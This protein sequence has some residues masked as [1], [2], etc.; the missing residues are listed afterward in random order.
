M[1]ST[2]VVKNVTDASHYYAA[3]DNYY[4]IEEGILKS[5]W[6]GRGSF[7][8]N[9][10]GAID[11][12]QFT[13]LLKGIMPN[14]EI[15]GK[16]VDDKIIHRAGWDLTFSA[17]KSVSLMALIAGDKRLVEAHRKAVHIALSE[18]ERGCSEARIKSPG[19]DVSYN[20]TR[21]MIAALFHHDLSRAEDPQLHTHS[22]VMN[23]TERTDGKWRS[24]ASKIGRY[25][26]DTQGEIHGFFERARHHK[27]Y[28]G[29]LYETE[30]AFQVQQLGYEIVIDEKTGVFQIK[31]VTNEVIEHFSKR[32]NEIEKYLK[33]KG[34]S[35]PNAAEVATLNTRENKVQ[36]D[37]VS[38][39]EKWQNES[40]K[41]RFNGEALVKE[42]EERLSKKNETPTLEPLQTATQIIQAS[43]DA[44]AQFK[45]TFQ[46]EELL[47]DASEIAIHKKC[48]V[49]ELLRAVDQL[50]EKG[51]LLSLENGEG[52]SY[53]MS[54]QT[55]KDE[56]TIK[57][58]LT[59]D[60][61]IQ[62]NTEKNQNY[63]SKFNNESQEFNAVST[64]LSNDKHILVGGIRAKELISKELI[65]IGKKQ[66][67]QLAIVSPNLITSK[68][69]ASDLK[70]EPVTFLE[71][72]KSL[73]V[74]TI[75]PH[76]STSQF[77]NQNEVK[78]PDA[79]LIENA[80][81]LSAKEQ[82]QLLQWGQH[83]NTKMVFYAEKNVLSSQKKG[84]DVNYL[85]EAGIKI[86]GLKEEQN[87]LRLD[88]T[89]ADVSAAF[90]KIS[91]HIVEVNSQEDRFHAMVNHFGRI[92]DHRGVYLV[93]NNKKETSQLN[94]LAHN[95]LKNTGKLKQG[96]TIDVLIPQFV[97]VHR[98]MLASSYE[99]GA[100]VRISQKQLATL[101]QSEYVKIIGVDKKQNEIL[102]KRSNNKIIHWKPE[103]GLEVFK[104]EKRE[105]GVGER[106]FSLRSMK[107]ANVTKGEEFTIAAMR[108]S[109]VKLVRDKGTPL[110][111]DISKPYQTHFEY[112]YAG[113]PHQL[114]HV[115]AKE[116]IA[117]MPASSFTTHQRQ[118]FQITQQPER[119]SI[120]TENQQTLLES[121]QKK[122]GDKLNAHEILQFSIDVKKHLASFYQ[123]L[124][125][126]IQKTG[127]HKNTLSKAAIDAV[128]YAMRHLAERNAGFDHKDLMEVA[129]SHAIGKVNR[130]GLLQALS[131]M[132]K[133]GILLKGMG[134]NGVLWTTQEALKLEKEILELTQKDQGRLSS[135]ASLAQVENHL[136]I[137]SLN[138]ERIA[139]IK[140]IMQSKD[141]VLT[142]QG[143]AGTGK[144][145]M[146]A[147]LSEVLAAKDIFQ[148]QGYTLQGIAP[149][150]K[151]VKEL[152]GRRIPAQTIDRFLLDMHH[153]NYE[154]TKW[155]KTILIVDEASMVS[156]RK[157]RDILLLAHQYNFRQVIP[158]GDTPHQ[159]GAVEAGKPHHLI[160]QILNEKVIRLEEIRRQKNEVLKEA[161]KAVYQMDVANTF[162]ILG[163]AVIEI[164]DEK[165]DVKNVKKTTPKIHARKS[166]ENLSYQK[167]VK[168]IAKDYVDLLA[169]N[170]NVQ[171]ITPSHE[172]RKAVNFEVRNQLEEKGKL[173]GPSDT[174][175]VLVA[176]NMTAVE[177]SSSKNFKA[178]YIVRFTEGVGKEI[179]AGDYFTIKAVDPKLNL[180]V[181]S[182]M[183]QE[184]EDILWPIPK[185]MQKRNQK[186]EVFWKEKR[187]LKVGD[188][189]VWM[190]TDRKEQV[191]SSEFANV[192]AI[193]H[194]KI[195][196]VREDGST[197]TFNG[198]D[199]K[200][201][202]WDHGYA[203]TAYGAQGGTYSTVLALFESYRKNLM[204]LKT[205]LVTLTRPENE[206]RIYTDDKHQLRERIFSNRGEKLSALEVIDDYP[207]SHKNKLSPKK[208]NSNNIQQVKYENKPSY[209]LQRIKEGLNANA[210]HLA[211]EILGQ[212]KIR[213]GHYLKFG[214]KQGSLSL[215]IKGEK[216]GWWNDFSENNSK[217]RSM[218]SFIEKQ[219]NMS[220]QEAIEFA[221][222]WLGIVP[223]V[224]E[225][226]TTKSSASIEKDIQE[227]KIQ[228]TDY[229]KKMQAKAKKIAKESISIAGTLA[230]IY[231]KKHRGIDPITMKITEDIRFHP[232]IYS[233]I[234]K[235]KLPALVSLVRNK[236]NEIISA[237]TIFLDRESGNKVPYLAVGKQT[238][239]AKK[240]G[241]VAVNLGEKK[242]TVILAE[243]TVT[244]LSVAKA[245]PDIPVKSL[246]GKQLL[247]AIDL[248]TLP[249]NIVICLDYD[250]KDLTL[251]KTI[252]EA[253]ERL[254]SHQKNV[255]FMVPDLKNHAK[256][257]YNDLLK[258]KGESQIR[259]DFKNAIPFQQ[260]YSQHQKEDVL[261]KAG[262][263]LIKQQSMEEKQK[264]QNAA[265]LIHNEKSYQ[266]NMKIQQKTN[267]VER[268][269]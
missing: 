136:Q 13:Q 199:Q 39:F 17:P 99:V 124:E 137:T 67:W 153:A 247:G 175:Q 120:Y 221:A 238:F 69:F 217:G 191:F 68:H 83:K 235:E 230:E 100:F 7:K 38:L 107:Y 59:Q 89:K 248:A 198:K 29:K 185:S 174:F 129:M 52:K 33:E 1:L 177:R 259:N 255:S 237:E 87:S 93:A 181:L 11:T 229:Q 258:I 178:G 23:L 166:E 109:R 149:T 63:L 183:E 90:T 54:H 127:G 182:K 135:I 3:T 257:D 104:L 165:E 94:V 111:I 139:A 148:E 20:R 103:K 211:I 213:G 41:L 249:K 260:F 34:F 65:E 19:G 152:R 26:K 161:V 51:E 81:L 79:L 157:M 261:F 267:Q 265:K 204:N 106:L 208:I 2:S 269:I 118:F 200:S 156:N 214:S 243:G 180:L 207:R 194:D 224:H 218:L 228:E 171:I 113:T 35:G 96:I 144:T 168:A 80:H 95:E 195:T 78:K 147:K 15:I 8:L 105:W 61:T 202:H 70:S 253:A 133:A 164:K 250:G 48:D 187:S 43:I 6:F 112:A 24:M 122:S 193:D 179:K 14:G 264:F 242:D 74:D 162:S 197:H 58:C 27:R 151:A 16:K 126:A 97:P 116:F 12:T 36:S 88:V 18:I 252:R 56:K 130:E 241:S 115:K 10:Q 141:R 75:I 256:Y 121:L 91:N 64:L 169:Q 47:L 184:K 32:R 108:G 192:T 46:L 239:G 246:L 225:K 189:M 84:V 30:L 114:A 140:T 123:I 146:M 125:G 212:P 233:S 173:T 25:D 196:V 53:L 22:V 203:V 154:K 98:A 110:V 119:V 263:S 31:G 76:Y 176:K 155:D 245:L 159:L 227:S 210:E 172:D 158:T 132:E 167:R 60:N 77:L 101:P 40:Q 251:D 186:I 55:L 215:T 163:K 142:I 205:F 266:D 244:A 219:C 44:I 85:I 131:A 216:A 82:A 128:D 236:N 134:N 45:T 86:I 222:R 143:R 9:L 254:Q 188:K 102:L 73:F 4:T 209:D 232:G 66:K 92:K 190:R 21:N 234:N 268:E 160:Q 145:T 226:F 220:K 206:L 223:S 28:F 49:K 170:E 138:A 231:L 50:V 262:M 57:N 72:F 240:G 37:R 201:Q 42:A 62:I 150:H 117:D 71:K 5:E